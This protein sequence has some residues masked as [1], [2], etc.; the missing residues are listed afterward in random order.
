MTGLRCASTSSLPAPTATGSGASWV[1]S[2]RA[3][4]PASGSGP[5]WRRLGNAL[6]LA[7]FPVCVLVLWA[8]W[9][10]GPGE[11]VVALTAVAAPLLTAAFPTSWW[12]ADARYGLTFF[13][14]MVIAA[15]LAWRRWQPSSRIPLP[16]LTTVPLVCFAITCAPALAAVAGPPPR[17]GPDSDVVELIRA[18]EAS[19]VR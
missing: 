11:R 19:E 3:A 14:V 6:L 12:T 10:A 18:I 16:A 17:G 13:P 9:R 7:L 2:S 4:R 8:L 1:R 5:G 15:G